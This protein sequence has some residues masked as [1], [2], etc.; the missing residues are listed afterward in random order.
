MDSCIFSDMFR[1]SL[2]LVRSVLIILLFAL[3]PGN[4]RLMAQDGTID[5]LRS[6]LSTSGQDT[7]RVDLLNAV[8]NYYYD[9]K[10]IDSLLAYANKAIELSQSLNYPYGKLAAYT[11]LSS[12]YWYVSN[13]DQ[14]LLYANM[15]K[16]L[17]IQ[18]N[19]R[20]LL[21]NNM[22]AIGL[23]NSHK[24]NFDVALTNYLDA[25]EIAEEINDLSLQSRVLNNVGYL[26]ISTRDYSG[27]IPVLMRSADINQQ[28][29]NLNRLAVNYNNLGVAYRFLSAYDS[30]FKYL[31][32]ALEISENIGFESEV[33]VVLRS[34]G[35]TYLQQN[36]LNQARD[37]TFRAIDIQ[38]ELSST[39][40][41]IRSLNL[42]A[43]IYLKLGNHGQAILFGEEALKLAIRVE[44]L[45]EESRSLGILHQASHLAGLD[46]R[47][48]EQLLAYTVARDSLYSQERAREIGRLESRIE[49]SKQEQENER[50]V[51]ENQLNQE[52]LNSKKVQEY[53]FIIVTGLL[54]IIVVG[55]IV[56]LRK[57]KRVSA[58][59]QKQKDALEEATVALAQSNEE[60]N[61][62]SSFKEGLT[63][64]I[65]HDMK[66]SLNSIIGFSSKNLNDHRMAAI[67]QSGHTILNLV[68]N[69]LDVQRFEETKV[70]LNMRRHSLHELMQ[71]AI[72]RVQLLRADRAVNVSIQSVKMPS[73][74]LDGELIIRVLVNLLSNA[75]KYSPQGS[76]VQIKTEV[77]ERDEQN[78]L[79]IAVKDQGEGINPTQLPYIFDKYWQND[80]KKS[81]STPS[82]GL[83]LTFCKLAIEAH[84]GTIYAESE[85]GNGTTIFFDLPL[86]E[87]VLVY[88]EVIDG[89]D[90]KEEV[91]ADDRVTIA[92]YAREMQ[93]MKIYQVKSLKD[94]LVQ[95][96]TEVSHSDWPKDMKSAIFEGNEDKFEQ[97][98][99]EVLD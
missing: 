38:R 72:E 3:D 60:L 70:Q 62:L 67:H 4:G 15:G 49:L 73:V 77:I 42:A 83:G 57:R 53:T 84:K 40:E 52:Q 16:A 92:R 58:E 32:Q 96:E 85:P 82:T 91:S 65:A 19:N 51:I 50:L 80:Q 74:E 89:F 8:S 26:Y 18:I 11:V 90:A 71:E 13:Y 20:E 61:Q 93:K 97:L 63:N 98:L 36:D 94:L 79:K 7:I 45:P 66:N 25:L 1:L 99:S 69:M 44:S 24:G 95:L 76:E 10:E 39:V 78:Y 56:T 75:I 47:A 46:D 55:G 17:G 6:Q 81:G 37:Y 12:G 22:I 54:L 21:A 31:D 48:Y 33:G 35:E 23:V 88:E 59:I 9:T 2:N 14:A 41:L 5:S 28:I 29:E 87:D 68:L 30:A 86:A 27:S 43:E 34:F 64:M